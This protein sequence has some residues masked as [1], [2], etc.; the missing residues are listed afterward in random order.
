MRDKALRFIEE[1]KLLCDG[2]KVIVA[3]SGGADSVSLLHFLCSLKEK[4]GLSVYALHLNHGIRGEEADRD[5]RFV[6]ALCKEWG[7]ELV[8][9]HADIPALSAERR[10]SLELCAREE[11]YRL[12][13]MYAERLGAKVA[14]AHTMSDNA[15]TVLLHL[16]RGSGVKGLCGIPA[17]RGAVI[18]PLL[19]CTRTEIEAYCAENGLEYVTDSTNLS[20]D[21]SRNKVRLSVMPVLKELNPAVEESLSRLCG[22][23]GEADKFL[24]KYSTE[25][26]KLCRNA[27]GYDCERLLAFDDAVRH[28]ALGH[29]ARSAGASPEYRHYA[30]I[31]AAMRTG[32]SV[33][34]PGGKRLSCA[35]GI[36]RITEE[37]DTQLMDEIPISDYPGTE[38]YSAEE[39]KNVH[40]K[41]SE[42]C[43]RCDIITPNTVIRR[44]RAG[45]TFTLP[46]R[47]VTKTVKKLFN[48]LHI[49]RERRD[50]L[51]L[52][53]EGSRVL[54]LE[55]VG[56][57][58]DARID[59]ADPVSAVYI[60]R[61]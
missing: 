24:D 11:R 44:R 28:Y 5:E 17:K 36:L 8:C 1:N 49:P 13:S 50:S 47:G 58:E 39:L 25:E 9:E 48:E 56:V 32:G 54:W 52:V 16:V 37:P 6:H 42:N 53:A 23:V 45:D 33:D 7:V 15:E 57:S 19:T 14:T 30:L 51:L 21:Y 3:L 12:F 34:L 22:T 31:E 46:Y 4:Y 27:Y 43:V 35:Q 59:P 10:Q 41:F 40:K 60:K 26:L 20:E 38:E 29:I 61:V 55:G 18:R 2:D